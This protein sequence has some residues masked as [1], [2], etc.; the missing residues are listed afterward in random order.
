MT[1]IYSSASIVEF[2][3]WVDYVQLQLEQ[4]FLHMR[5][6]QDLWTDSDVYALTLAGIL[7]ER[8]WTVIPRCRAKICICMLIQV[9]LNKDV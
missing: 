9:I 8:E 4:L 7:Y 1:G 2:R 5:R 3:N 6:D